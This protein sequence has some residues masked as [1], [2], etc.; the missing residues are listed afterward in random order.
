MAD[1]DDRL[2]CAADRG[3]DV[4]HGGAR[5]EPLVDRELDSG[6][7][8]DRGGGLAGAE[9]RARDD[10]VGR[11]GRQPLCERARLLAA[12]SAER[13]QLVRVAGS[14]WAWRTRINRTAGG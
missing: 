1:G 6:G 11:L 5:R 8:R 14:E 7:L 2:A 12:A 4:V 10:G 3:E 13:A 9:K